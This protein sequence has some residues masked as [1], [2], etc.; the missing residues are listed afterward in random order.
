M[1]KKNRGGSK[2]EP[3]LQPD[4]SPTNPKWAQQNLSQAPDVAAR[5]INAC[6]CK[7]LRFYSALLY[8][9]ILIDMSTVQSKVLYHGRRHN[10]EELSSGVGTSE[11]EFRLCD[12]WAL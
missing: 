2:P 1:F 10:G 3:K 6:C 12:L 8:L 4:A 5:K 11:F 9:I 7:L